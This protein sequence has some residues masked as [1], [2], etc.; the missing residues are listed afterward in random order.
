[1]NGRRGNIRIKKKNRRK[2][3]RKGKPGER[4]KMQQEIFGARTKLDHEWETKSR[5]KTRIER[6]KE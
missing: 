3:R 6:N 1:M 2:T 5:R 4:R